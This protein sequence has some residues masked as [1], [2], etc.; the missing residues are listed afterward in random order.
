[1]GWDAKWTHTR[2]V[3]LRG[4][5]VAN[6]EPSLDLPPYG[7][8][9]L[10]CVD[11][12]E[13]CDHC[14][15]KI[16]FLHGHMVPD[17]TRDLLCIRSVNARSLLF[18]SNILR[19]RCAKNKPQHFP[20]AII[21][22]YFRCVHCTALISGNDRDVYML[23]SDFKIHDRSTA[24][25][26]FRPRVVCVDTREPVCV[27]MWAMMVYISQSIQNDCFASIKFYVNRLCTINWSFS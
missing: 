1:M 23:R 18:D 8:W 5:D 7:F 9:P 25:A 11:V 3:D 13:D 19:L 26:C 24:K 21:F 17:G 20:Y 2:Q 22:P 15:G 14:R 4:C 10:S 12:W 6:T 27:R 16:I